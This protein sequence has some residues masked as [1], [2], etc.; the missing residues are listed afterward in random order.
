MSLD[1]TKDTSALL[2][3][4]LAGAIGGLVATAVKTMAEKIYPPRTHGEPEPPDVA[5]EKIAGHP[6]DDTTKAAASEGIHWVFGAAAGGF[7][8]VLAEIYPAV[9]AKSGATFGLTLMSLTHE[10]AL[11]ALGLSEPHEDQ[12]LRERTSEGATHILYGVVTEKVRGL[13]RG[14]LD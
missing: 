8:G 4:L 10:G 9:T 14:M 13:V 3:G 1:Q 6:L 11:P 12:T 7:Y 5:A 2:K